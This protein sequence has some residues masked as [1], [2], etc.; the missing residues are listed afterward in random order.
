MN[1]HKY[2][3]SCSVQKELPN[4]LQSKSNSTIIVNVNLSSIASTNV[5]EHHTQNKKSAGKKMGG[6]KKKRG[7]LRRDGVEHAKERDGEQQDDSSDS[8]GRGEVEL[9][10]SDR[11][12][13]LAEEALW[14]WF[15]PWTSAD[16]RHAAR[17]GERAARLLTHAWASGTFD[18]EAGDDPR[19]VV[20][21]VTYN[22]LA[23][24]YIG[25]L[26]D[27]PELAA[28]WPARLAL[29]MEQLRRA[30][31]PDI[32]CL[33]EV[34]A[35][36]RSAERD[37]VR[38]VRAALAVLGYRS[39]YECKATHRG[40]RVSSD[41]AIGN[42]VAWRCDRWEPA[43]G[44]RRPRRG[45][46]LAAAVHQ[47][48]D[49]MLPKQRELYACQLNQVATVAVL[50]RVGQPELP[51]LLVA[52][53]HLTSDW[54]RHDRQFCQT[55]CLLHELALLRSTLP[56]AAAVVLAGDFNA[57]TDCASYRL[58]VDGAVPIER[59]PPTTMGVPLP[60]IPQC[61]GAYVAPKMRSAYATVTGAEPPFTN[62]AHDQPWRG[63]LDYVFFD[64]D[65]NAV[66]VSLVHPPEVY[67]EAGVPVPTPFHPSDH[68]PIFARFQFGPG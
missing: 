16:E 11:N 41:P 32:V 26:A 3:F 15:A 63:T 44:V 27:V 20:E 8:D 7:T 18:G 54:R 9:M 56:R 67:H 55:S 12:Q 30:G 64:G 66:D 38:Q 6:D 35:S 49:K 5:M 58:V 31:R 13:A 42:I 46:S 52:S 14:R 29:V 57:D 1:T 40:R 4:H 39:H 47:R 48:C 62:F 21:V 53:V 10:T 19:A 61:D 17:L 68:V 37:A 36:A 59:V 2:Y 33:Q 50:Q 51:L 24:M 28:A 25:Y 43:S 65:L 23:P 60:D 34:Q 22:I 45:I